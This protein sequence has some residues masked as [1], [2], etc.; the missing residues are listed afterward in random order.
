M[1]VQKDD[2]RELT[3]QIH[4]CREQIYGYGG[5]GFVDVHTT[6]FKT[7]ERQR[8]CSRGNAALYPVIICKWE[9]NFKREQIHVCVQQTAEQRREAKGKGEKE[10][11][12]HLN[13]EF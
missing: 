10:R 9:E 2:R 4:R 6:V 1:G 12:I 7:D 3:K 13:A 5:G 8:L 11:Y